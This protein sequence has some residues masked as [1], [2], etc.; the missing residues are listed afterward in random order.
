[1]KRGLDLILGGLAIVILF[2]PML[3]VAIAVRLTSPGPILFWSMRVGKNNAILMMPK[4]RTMQIDTP[5]VATHLLT[6]AQNYLTPIGGFLRR[7][8]LDELPQLWSV[9]LGRMSFVG[10][11]PALYNQNDLIAMRNAKG[12]QVLVPGITG[13][14]QVNGRDELDL[15][16]KVQ[17]DYEYLQRRSTPFDCYI[18]F[19]TGKKVLGRDGVAH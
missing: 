12:L 8:S 9:L 10:P 3:L 6:G 2:I 16:Q 5:N 4:F 13:W 17:L 7:S 1:M 11:R 18:L 15:E 19:L 14:A